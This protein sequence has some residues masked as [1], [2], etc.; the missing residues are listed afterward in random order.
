MGDDCIEISCGLRRSVQMLNFGC[1]VVGEKEVVSVEPV[2]H[3]YFPK[4][5]SQGGS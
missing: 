1:S 4:S 5:I 3:G 2:P